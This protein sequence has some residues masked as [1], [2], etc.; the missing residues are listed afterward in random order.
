MRK[1]RKR[2]HNDQGVRNEIDNFHPC[3]HRPVIFQLMHTEHAI[4]ITNNVIIRRLSGKYP[5]IL[6]ISRT[7]RVALMWLG[8]QRLTGH[9]WTA[10]LPWDKPVGNEMPLIEFVCCVT[11]A[12][13]NTHKSE[14]LSF[15]RTMRLTI[16][17]LTCRLFFGQIITS[18]RSVSPPTG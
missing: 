13:I 5:S 2:N 16:L 9:P 1:R 8:R 4:T 15:F 3:C 10:I 6:K 11:L 18:P 14:Q 7:G 17:Q 12:I